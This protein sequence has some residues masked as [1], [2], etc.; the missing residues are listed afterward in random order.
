VEPSVH[1][2]IQ[3]CNARTPARQ[4]EYDY[5]VRRNLANPWIAKVHNLIEQET[6]IPEEFRGHGKYVEHPLGRWMTYADALE[7]ANK[8]LDGQT[9]CLANL[10]IFLDDNETQWS[11]TSPLL[12]KKAVLCLSRIEFDEQG[13]THLDAGF[14]KWAF[15]NTQDA[16]IFRAPFEVPNCDFEIGTIGCDNAFADRVRQAGRLPLNAPGR[17][18]I[19]HYDRCRGKSFA[20]QDDFY[21]R[22]RAERPRR[23]PE[24]EGQF[25]VPDIDRLKSVDALL[26]RLKVPELQRY[27]L[28]CE[29]MSRFI[30]I[31]NK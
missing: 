28:I 27:A 10:D 31:R 7:Y 9:V 1:I 8:R 3:Y 20:N 24:D 16:W 18:K 12:D 22:E 30:R 15:A 26:D 4:A 6:S 23:R 14:L 29:V 25:L 13:K 2:L 19:Y 11:E 21:A 17:F 5:C